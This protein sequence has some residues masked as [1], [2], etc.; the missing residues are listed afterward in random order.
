[1]SL[2]FLPTCKGGMEPCDPVDSAQHAHSA[3]VECTENIW[4]SIKGEEN[5]LC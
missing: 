2:F 1:M 3:S 5:F 4:C